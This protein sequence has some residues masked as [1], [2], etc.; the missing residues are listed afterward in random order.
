MSVTG[1]LEIT[2]PNSSGRCSMQAA[3][4]S[5][6]LLPPS[7]ASL[8]GRNGVW[9]DLES[10][11]VEIDNISA[12]FKHKEIWIQITYYKPPSDEPIVNVFDGMYMGGET[13]QL[14]Q[15]GPGCWYLQ[16]GVWRVGDDA[17]HEVIDIT[18]GTIGMTIDQIV[19]D[20][21]TVVCNDP[22]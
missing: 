9:G 2:A 13:I 10:I 8:L 3:V 19:V 15:Y 14:E 18:T 7:I 12:P 22:F 4:K 20:T 11:T 5:P 6:P 16:Q 1:T 17:D 21:N